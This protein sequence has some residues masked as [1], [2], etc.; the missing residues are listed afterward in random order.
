[1]PSRGTW[2]TGI[3]AI[4]E[5]EPDEITIWGSRDLSAASIAPSER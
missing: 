1:L 2:A 5:L 4:I 3:A